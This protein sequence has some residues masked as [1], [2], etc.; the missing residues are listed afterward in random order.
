MKFKPG[1]RVVYSAFVFDFVKHDEPL[2]DVGQTGT[3]L[4]FSSSGKVRV[5]FDN[6]DNPVDVD[7]RH[8]EYEL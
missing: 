3:V 6:K 8:L 2:P 1:D 7:H 5:K 4:N